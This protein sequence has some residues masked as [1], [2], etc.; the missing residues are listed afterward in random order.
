[1]PLSLIRFNLIDPS[2]NS[3]SLSSRYQ[4]MLE[5][6]EFVDKHGFFMATF[7]E[8]HG[9]DNAW[10][11]TP[12]INAATVLARTK[13][14]SASISALLLPLH[15][16]IRVAEDIAVIDLMSGGRLTVILGLGYR[17]S[18]YQLMGKDWENRGK[19]MDE[20]VQT[21]LDAWTGEPFEY[22]GESHQ[23]TPSPVT[24]PHPFIMIGGTSKVAAR[25]AARFGLPLSPAAHL[26]E[27]EAYYYEQCE[28]HGT[29][30]FC[31]MPDEET[32]MTFVAEDPDKAWAEL[33]QFFLNEASKY[34]SWQT[35]D[36][37]SAVHSH[38][39]TPNELRKEGIYQI[40]TP[41]EAVQLERIVHHP[42]CG[43]MPVDKA[44]ESLQ[45]YADALAD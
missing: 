3:E 18:E 27:L 15:D 1:M 39:T 25:R 43:G 12:L 2:L 29:Q 14:L 45:L 30:G 9:A 8:H 13:N 11:P 40:V 7:E 5:M 44:W 34:A 23:I 41:S 26:P 17:P 10:S 37:S 6:A 28:I 42:L 38:A 16:P 35:S 19:L 21:L 22:R 20:S 31:A 36:I 33:G 24:K 32:Q 4:A